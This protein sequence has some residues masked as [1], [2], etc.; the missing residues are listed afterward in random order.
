M[1]D[2]LKG[3]PFNTED[4]GIDFPRMARE[5]V[6]EQVLNLGVEIPIT[7]VYIVWFGFILGNFKAICSTPEPDGRIYEVTYDKARSLAFVDTYR[8][9]HNIEINIVKKEQ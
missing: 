5:L 8:K 7:A 1:A 9:T 3:I 2:N 6:H 4:E